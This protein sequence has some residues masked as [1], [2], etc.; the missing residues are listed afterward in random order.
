M[1]YF[2]A[3]YAELCRNCVFRQ[4]LQGQPI[5]RAFDIG[6]SLCKTLHKDDYV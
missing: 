4:Y 5:N 1:F 6:I 3:F 2:P